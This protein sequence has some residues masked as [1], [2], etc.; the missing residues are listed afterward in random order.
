MSSVYL[1]TSALLRMLLGEKGGDM[2]VEQLRRSERVVASRLLRVEAERVLIRLGLERPK[3]HRQ[4]LE[5]QRELRIFWPKVDF[6]EITPEICDLAGRV[7][8]QSRLRSLDAIHL[9]TY[10]RLRQLEPGLE[11]LTFDDRI[12]NEL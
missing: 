11:M 4:L 6:L 1:E 5:L 12:M 8:P 2:V 10:F 7:A 3:S 9:A